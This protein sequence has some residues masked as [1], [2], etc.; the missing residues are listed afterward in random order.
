MN[1]PLLELVLNA[2]WCAV[3]ALGLTVLWRGRANSVRFRWGI[4]F[5]ALSCV[6]A[7]L[8]PVISATDDLHSSEFTADDSNSARKFLKHIESGQHNYDS[9]SLDF[10]IRSADS[11]PSVFLIADRVSQIESGL[12]ELPR[13]SAVSNRAPPA[14][15]F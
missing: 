13:A 1:V 5:L 10:A 4:A 3:A 8:F 11:E 9:S 6:M 12:G 2:I 14:F 7:L 15:A